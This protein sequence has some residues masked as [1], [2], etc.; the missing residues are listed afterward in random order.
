MISKAPCSI[1]PMLV[2]EIIAGLL[3]PVLLRTHL[4]ILS[5]ALGLRILISSAVCGFKCN[6]NN[7]YHHRVLPKGRSFAANPGTRAAILP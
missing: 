5:R 6:H 3:P 7:Q 1:I 4:P 2:D